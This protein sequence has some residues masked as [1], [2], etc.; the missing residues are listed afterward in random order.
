MVTAHMSTNWD[1]GFNQLGDTVAAGIDFP[2][3]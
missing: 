3:C 1:A 2:V